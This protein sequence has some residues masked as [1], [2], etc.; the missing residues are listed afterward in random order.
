MEKAN[1]VGNDDG[2]KIPNLEKNI[3]F[4]CTKLFISL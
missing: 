2:G 1:E 3:Q 4:L